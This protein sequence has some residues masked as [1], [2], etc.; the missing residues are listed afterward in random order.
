MTHSQHAVVCLSGGMDS[1]SL[2]LHLL[3]KGCKVYGLS[4]DYG[5]KH[6]L[7]L[8]RFKVNLEYRESHGHSVA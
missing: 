3:A 7:E 8:E 6:K 2:M 1:T 4:F 5:L